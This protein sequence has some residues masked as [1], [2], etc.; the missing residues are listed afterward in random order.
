VEETK[1]AGLRTK[2]AARE[3]V[4]VAALAAVINSFFGNLSV[5]H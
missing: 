1:T 2:R 4:A 3:A 5:E